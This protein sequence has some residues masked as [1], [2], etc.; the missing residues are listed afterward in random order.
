MNCQGAIY[1]EEYKDGT[2]IKQNL[3]VTKTKEE[4]RKK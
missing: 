3:S 4:C 1:S 2:E